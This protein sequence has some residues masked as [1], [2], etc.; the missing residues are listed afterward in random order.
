MKVPDERQKEK[1]LAAYKT[2]KGAPCL[3]VHPN[4]K[5]KSGKFDCRVESLSVLLDYRWVMG[6]LWTAVLRGGDPAIQGCGSGSELFG[7]I[8][9]R[10][11]KIF[12]VSGSYRYF[13]N[14]KLHKKGE[15]KINN[16]GFTHFQVKFF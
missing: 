14:V 12:T 8:R 1:I 16:R 2:Q 5:V 4:P 11:R 9:S 6:V 13:G 10:M 15:K 3:F 7:R